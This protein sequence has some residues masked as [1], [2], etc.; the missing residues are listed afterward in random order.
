MF[1]ASVEIHAGYRGVASGRPWRGSLAC[2]VV[3]PDDYPAFIG[4]FE[5]NETGVYILVDETA[6]TV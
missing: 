2:N 1:A 6:A 5:L 3:D 4:H